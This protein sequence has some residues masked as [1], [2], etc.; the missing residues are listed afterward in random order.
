MDEVAAQCF[1]AQGEFS[2]LGQIPAAVY[3]V[4]G[5]DAHAQRAVKG[6]AHGCKNFQRKTHAILRTAAVGVG[7]LVGNGRQ[8]LVEQIAV[9]AVQLNRLDANAARAPGGGYKR[10]AHLRHVVQAHGGRGCLRRQL[11][12]GGRCQSLPATLI[13]PNQLPALPRHRAGRLA[14]RMR[15]LN[16]HRHGR[17]QLARTV[18]HV[19]QRFFG[20]VVPQPEAAVGD[21]PGLGHRRGLDCQQASAAVEQA[22][23]VRQMPV[24]GRAIVG[25]VLAHRCNDDAV[26]KRQAASWRRQ[27]KWG[28]KQAHAGD[29]QSEMRERQLCHGGA[30]TP[31]RDDAA[32]KETQA[33]GVSPNTNK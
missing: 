30:R 14:A 10:V 17:R 26:G 29:F 24:V 20:A 23:P 15:E 22:G 31:S 19:A 33:P 18:Q 8:E 9:S 12:Q 4:G 21:A 3:P 16:T 6:L 13:Q 25:Q 2:G 5:G 11:G 32:P 7:A 27:G 28:E 1:E